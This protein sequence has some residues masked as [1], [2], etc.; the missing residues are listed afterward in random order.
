MNLDLMLAQLR[1]T[2][3]TDVLQPESFSQVRPTCVQGGCRRCAYRK[4]LKGDFLCGRC[5][6]DRAPGVT[7]RFRDTPKVLLSFC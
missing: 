4:R 7:G 3:P 6:D 5:R 2:L 1:G